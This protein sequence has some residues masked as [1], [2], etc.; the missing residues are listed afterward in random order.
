VSEG[1]GCI[2]F[3]EGGKVFR[4]IGIRKISR[5]GLL[6]NRK[7]TGSNVMLIIGPKKTHRDPPNQL[8]KD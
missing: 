8:C 4:R 2:F 5:F 6:N 1:C 3:A 7:S